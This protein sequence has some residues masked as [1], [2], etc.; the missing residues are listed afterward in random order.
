MRNIRWVLVALAS[1]VALNVSWY[2]LQGIRILLGYEAVG[3]TPY[4]VTFV[5]VLLLWLMT[6]QVVAGWI[7]A[8]IARSHRVLHGVLVGVGTMVIYETAANISGLREPLDWL[9][10]AAHVVKILGGAVGGWF[11][12]RQHAPTPVQVNAV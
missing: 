6:V 1:F 10:I 9:S 12:E 5:S 3:P 7:V 2:G 11:A 4:T 8:R